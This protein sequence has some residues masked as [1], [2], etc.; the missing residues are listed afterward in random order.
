MGIL[1]VT[2]DSFSDGGRYTT[3]DQALARAE[4]M[5]AEGARLIDIGGESTRPGA[6]SVDAE[7]ELRRV[8]PVV[9]ALVGRWP[10]VLL[11]IDTAKAEVA[12]RCFDEGVHLLNDVSALS[13]P[14]MPDV[15]RTHGAPVVLM[16]RQGLPG[17]M[18]KNP[19][20]TD[21]VAEVHAF[22][23]E[24]LART[25]AQGIPRDRVI[26]DPGI[27]FGK[28]TAHNV[29]LLRALHTFHAF[30]CP[31]LVGLSR[32]TFLGKILGSEE[33]P[34]P[35]EEREEGGLAAHLWAASQGV[36]ILRVHDVGATARALRVWTVLAEDRGEG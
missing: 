4:Q 3:L 14:E 7:E 5:R 20:Y 2:P 23:E 33:S 26:L 9:R 27:G 6:V 10:E 29:A 24:R 17:T 18:Q 30:G 28:T 32:K 8:L 22:F 34:L 35:P 16:H 15:L 12:R 1:N 31:L 21:V 36:K 11:S 19:T 13:D 25:E